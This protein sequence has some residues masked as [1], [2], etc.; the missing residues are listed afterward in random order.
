MPDSKYVGKDN[1]ENWPKIL[2]EKGI[3]ALQY[4][5]I[6]VKILSKYFNYKLKVHHGRKTAAIKGI[7][8]LENALGYL[9]K[10]IELFPELFNSHYNKGLI[11]FEMGDYNT[12]LE[13]FEKASSLWNNH[14]DALAWIGNNYLELGRYDEA[15]KASE[16]AI[17]IDPKSRMARSLR[18]KIINK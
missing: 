4:D 17:E 2:D 8:Y 6:A 15:L 12:S 16:K 1:I 13:S 5:N 11:L 7:S 10:A 3:F 18:N 9:D 14:A